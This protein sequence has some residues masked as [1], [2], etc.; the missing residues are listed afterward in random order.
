MAI[1]MLV[2]VVVV[3]VRGDEPR[4]RKQ[5]GRCI[6]RLRAVAGLDGTERRPRRVVIGE[7][8]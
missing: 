1:M 2:V 3:V 4:D 7:M 6:G 8:T 5:L